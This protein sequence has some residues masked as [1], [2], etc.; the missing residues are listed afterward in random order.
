[1]KSAHCPFGAAARMR[2]QLPTPPVLPEHV[3]RV[4]KLLAIGVGF[5]CG[6]RLGITWSSGEAWHAIVHVAGKCP[7]VLAGL[8][9]LGRRPVRRGYERSGGRT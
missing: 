9:V 5:L 2:A 8:L 7:F 4:M 6:C 1:M 3:Q